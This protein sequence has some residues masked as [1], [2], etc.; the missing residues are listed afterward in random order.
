LDNKHSVFG[1]VA[2]DESLKNFNAIPARDPGNLNADKVMLNKVIIS[3][4]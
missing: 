4:S 1:K 3:E 2:D